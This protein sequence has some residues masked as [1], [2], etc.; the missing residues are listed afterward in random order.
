MAGDA[1]LYAVREVVISGVSGE[2][3]GASKR[4]HVG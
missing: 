1:V 2:V 3:S 4:H